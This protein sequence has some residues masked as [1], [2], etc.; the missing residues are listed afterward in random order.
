MN[1]EVNLGQI[2]QV[3][4]LLV[5]V[6]MMFQ[7]FKSDIKAH[8]ARLLAV[9]TKL[10]EITILMT[11]QARQEERMIALDK[12]MQAQGERIDSQA[13]IINGR[14]EA[15]NNIV[16]GHTAHLNNLPRKVG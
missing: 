6:G 9:E 14:L 5:G 7:S 10:S 16:A 3:G 15:I 8:A 11:G 1:W 4:A 12:R 13:L 2:L